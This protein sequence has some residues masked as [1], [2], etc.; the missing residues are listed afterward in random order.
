[1]E[2]RIGRQE[3]TLSRI[4]PYLQT[5]G[6]T[7]VEL[8][9]ATGRK[10]MLWQAGLL[11]DILAKN[12][13]GKWTHTRFGY[14]VSRRNGKGEVLIARE[15]YAL[16]MNE[17]VLHTAHLTS[18]SH[19]A[20]ERLCAILDQLG[21]KYDSIKAK[22]QEYISIKGGGRLDFR[23]RTS[24]GAL[25]EGFDLLIIDEAQEYRVEHQTA[26][27]YVVSASKNP[28]TIMCGTPPTAVSAGTVFKDYRDAVLAGALQNAGWA[29][30]SVKEISDPNDREL[31]YETNP[32]IGITLDERAIMDEVG[33]SESERIDFNIQRLGLWLKYSQ[34]SAI[35]Q[36]AWDA[37]R[38]KD[39]EISGK[40]T[41]GIK[42]NRD[43]A[44]VS[45]ALAAYSGDKIFLEV[46]GR[47]STREG[48]AW[49][50]DGLKQLGKNVSR[51]IIDGAGSADIL[52][53]E[54][55][56]EKLRPPVW[57]KV[58]EII[59]AGQGFENAVYQQT[60]CHAGQPSLRNVV[61]NCEHRA[62]GSAGGFGF[63][64]LNESLDISLMESVV[65]AHWGRVNFKDKKQIISY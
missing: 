36:A 32:S 14:A 27:K 12:E 28:Q 30:W 43:G 34:Q 37:C 39:P 9:E 56:S 17:K 5:D 8:Y 7:A 6:N 63:S 26:L 42:Y 15:L 35:S 44:S 52:L 49:I 62:I 10:A 48:N 41:I 23:T 2:K 55:A 60:I 38:V 18:T 59:E 29:E 3:P 58:K 61:S 25:G 4:L 40:V 1:M 21:I 51:V 65:L 13:D 47:K 31:W 54:M 16:A 22:G 24:T 53:K 20:W 50:L 19:S 33:T 46:L 57:P 45:M 64:P 11:A